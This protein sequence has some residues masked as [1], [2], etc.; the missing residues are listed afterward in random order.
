CPRLRVGRALGWAFL[1][2]VPGDPRGARNVRAA[3]RALFE[4]L[5]PVIPD[6]SALFTVTG[7]AD[8]GG[9]L[10]LGRDVVVLDAAADGGRD[11]PMLTQAL[12]ARGRRVFVLGH[13]LDGVLGE[14]ARAGRP[15]PVPL[16]PSLQLF[17]VAAPSVTPPAPRPGAVSGAQTTP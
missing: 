14:F 2:H 15:R 17:E 11:A 7:L 13:S 8:V 10:Q 12:L 9:L 6:R 5:A 4:A 1:A 16:T 3:S